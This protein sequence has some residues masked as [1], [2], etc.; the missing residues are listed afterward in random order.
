M[1]ILRATVI[2]IKKLKRLKI[3]I[4]GLLCAILSVIISCFQML[5]M[6]NT[7]RQFSLLA[8]GTIWN[9]VTLLMPFTI[10]LVGGYYI[11][12][13]FVEDTQKN[14]L[15]IPIEWRKII[16]AKIT[17]LFLFGVLLGITEW[18]LCIVASVICGCKGIDL[19]IMFGSLVVMIIVHICIVIAVLPI[20]LIASSKKGTYVWGALLSM[21]LGVLAVFINNGKGVNFYPLTA[22]L[23]II[24]FK[25]IPDEIS[26]WKIAFISLILF[27]LFSYVIYQI[28]YKKRVNLYH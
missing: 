21:I 15:M 28:K 9:N 16:N 12:R 18:I 23:V 22:G 26:N 20:I 2:E 13:E 27:S 19:E 4:V 6:S 25:Q 24:Q 17:L 14:I 7:D 5:V 3:N 10:A 1:S 11:N 8:E